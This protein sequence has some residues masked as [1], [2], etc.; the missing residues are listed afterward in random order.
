MLKSRLLKFVKEALRT[1]HYSYRTEQAY[2]KWIRR[3]INYYAN[4]HPDQLDNT[5]IQKYLSH[6]ANHSNIAASTQN[7][8]RAAIMF[9]Y[10]EV[11]DKAINLNSDEID[12][13]NK[14]K[15]IPTVFSRKEALK[16]LQLLDGDKWLM[17]SLLY[18]AGLRLM[19]CIRLRVKDIDFE[20]SQVIVRDGKG[21]KDRA[22]VLPAR[23][24][25]PLHRQI[26]RV[27]AL[28]E[29][30]RKS[31]I[32]G[33]FMPTALARKYPNAARELP[34]QF[35]F[36]SNRLSRDPR[37]GKKR[38]HHISDS[39]LQRAVRIA[40][41]QANIQKAASCHTFR[42]SFATHLL[43][44][45][46]DIRTVQ[47]LLGHSDVRTTMIYTHIVKRGGNAILSPL[48]MPENPPGQSAS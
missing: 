43:E 10:R 35:L 44:S 30:D 23:L 9:L 15:R 17:A 36:P 2:L 42:H 8:A 7:Q 47:E 3:F 45:G 20:M 48:D 5:H 39:A 12:Y 29:N 16:V 40:V 46:Y 28:L 31:G 34:W 38:R 4:A 25:K 1:K 21:A 32:G 11:L 19:E 24:E 6:L 14:P 37:T 26:D 41:K 27:E 13:A 18:G 22:T 33:V